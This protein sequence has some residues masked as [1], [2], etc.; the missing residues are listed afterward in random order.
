[1]TP[2]TVS[3]LPDDPRQTTVIVSVLVVI[4]LAA[5]EG[6]VTSTIMPSVIAAIGGM[7]LYP[8]ATASFMLASTVTTPIYGKLSDVYGRKRFVLIAIAIFLVGSVLCG[9]ADDMVQLIAFRAVQG[10]GAGGLLTMSFIIFGVLFSAERRARMQGLLS[11]MWALASIAGPIIGALCVQSLSWRWAFFLNVPIGLVAA[12]MIARNLQLPDEPNRTYRMDYLGVFLFVA[13]MSA[14]LGAS[15]ALTAGHGTAMLW[16]CTGLAAG[17]F[18]LLIVHE[19]RV[20]EPILPIPMFRQPAFRLSVAMAAIGTAGFFATMTLLPVYLQGVMGAAPATT[21]QAL[22]AISVGWAVGA[23]LSGRVLHAL[24][25][26]TPALIGTVMIVSA[27]LAFYWSSGA[28]MLWPLIACCAVLGLGMG[29]MATA[30]LMAIQTS[31]PR[32]MLGAATSGSQLF[33]TIGGT[34]GISLFGGLQL[35]YFTR[36]LHALAARNPHPA[37]ARIVEEPHL[38]LDV[39]GRKLLPPDVL[40]QATEILADSIHQVFLMAALFSAVSVALASRMPE[41][42]GSDDPKG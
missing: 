19:R 23:G 33:R 2:I 16:A 35:G 3:H 20:A 8:W 12:G 25:F 17:L 30:T 34:L 36:G 14:L 39:A 24:G 38:I 11:S 27:Y 42:P 4:F 9:V 21:G 22:I 41:V 18:T 5:M 29:G 10:I 28:G 13:S 1:M 26:R 6:M 37:L 31:A 40:V 32:E 7:S 15:M